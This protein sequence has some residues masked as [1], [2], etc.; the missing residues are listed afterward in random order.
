VAKDTRNDPNAGDCLVNSDLSSSEKTPG[1]GSPE[2]PF[3]LELQDISRIRY[4]T[5][6]VS[7][8]DRH[9]GC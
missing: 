4:T 9:F 8:D 6:W 7:V 2:R 5:F 1:L 3:S